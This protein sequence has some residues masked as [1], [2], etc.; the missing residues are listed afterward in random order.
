MN[1]LK[2]QPS[3]DLAPEA[4]ITL[5]LARKALLVAPVVIL[6]AGLIRGGAGAASA[7]YALGVVVLNLGI[8]AL[9]AVTAARFSPAAIGAAA[10]VGY[11]L[12]L[13]LVLVSVLLVRNASWFDGW[14]LGLTLI[15]AHLGLLVWEARKISLSFTYPALTPSGE[16]ATK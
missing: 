10:L 15:T 4:Q 2:W 3:Q 11:P 8:A 9:L 13:G 1:L 12:R 14:T 5:D 6:L 7:A 16:A